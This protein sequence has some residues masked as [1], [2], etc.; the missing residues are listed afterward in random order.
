MTRKHHSVYSPLLGLLAA[1]FL[2]ALAMPPGAGAA[3]P[4]GIETVV[5]K[6]S[7]QIAGKGPAAAREQAIADSLDAAVKR[8]VAGVI[9]PET[10]AARPGVIKEAL[11][12]KTQTFIDHYRVLREAEAGTDYQV[13]VEVAVSVPRVKKELEQAGIFRT[14][15]VLPKVLLLTSQQNLNDFSPQYWWSGTAQESALVAESALEAALQEKGYMVI[16]SRD[17][18]V[19]TTA[20]SMRYTANPDPRQAADIGSRTGADIVIIGQSVVRAASGDTGEAVRA[21]R[22]TSSLLAIGVDSASQLASATQEFVAEAGDDPAGGL[23]ALSGAGAAAGKALAAPLLTA[24]QAQ[25]QMDAFLRLE[26]DNGGRLVQ[27]VRFRRI[28]EQTS[29]V[30]EMRIERLRPTS[31]VIAVGF[32]GGAQALARAL[33][34]GAYESFGINITEITRKGIKLQLVGRI[35]AAAVQ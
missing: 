9:P 6:G 14:A 33:N 2:M 28:L 31:A 8:V 30:H 5:V 29:G 22:A 18:M 34:A 32:N 27:F 7:R 3:S 13:E 35:G 11:S 19:R 26:V 4:A 10:L 20:A 23:K 24:W 1:G 15:E 17:A 25:E 12:G 16:S 21:Y